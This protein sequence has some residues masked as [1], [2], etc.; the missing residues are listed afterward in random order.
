MGIVPELYCSDF[1][2]S[3]AFYTS[4]CGFSID[5]SRDEERFAYLRR[6]EARLMIEQT[7][8]PS[9]RFVAAELTYPFGR[10]MNLE[11][12]VDDASTLYDSVVAGGVR[13]FLDLE[14]RWYR[15]GASEV[16]N[17]QFV[18]MDPDGYLLRFAQDLGRREAGETWPLM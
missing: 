15:R 10:G 12:P 16:G 6:G 14:E 5:Y 7:R 4:V 3:L 8:D 9:R 13:I 11:I 1:D 2:A 17:L 18:A